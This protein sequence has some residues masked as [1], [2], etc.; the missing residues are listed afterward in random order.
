MPAGWLINPDLRTPISTPMDP[1]SFHS[2][3]SPSGVALTQELHRPFNFYHSE[4]L[5]YPGDLHAWPTFDEGEL[6]AEL[7]HY[8]SSVSKL[9]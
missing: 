7:T 4:C 1:E 9:S 2:Q 5:A 8:F 6:V 3:T